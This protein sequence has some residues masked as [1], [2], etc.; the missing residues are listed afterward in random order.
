MNFWNRF[1]ML[2][3]ECWSIIVLPIK[4][5]VIIRAFHICCIWDPFIS[6]QA[7]SEKNKNDVLYKNSRFQK[8][9]L[10]CLRQGGWEQGNFLWGERKGLFKSILRPM[11]FF[12]ESEDRV[13]SYNVSWYHH[14]Q[15]KFLLLPLRQKRRRCNFSELG[16]KETFSSTFLI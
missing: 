11:E 15:K 4:A 3:P 1:V 14:H 5:L 12:S 8:C 10:V 2:P 9:V 7:R 6:R 16:K 13:F